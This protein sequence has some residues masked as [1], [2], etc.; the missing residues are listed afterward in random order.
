MN[1]EKPNLIDVNIEMNEK[2]FFRVINLYYNE[3]ELQKIIDSQNN[4][5]LVEEYYLI[6][7]DWIEAFK[8]VFH[9]D[10]NCLISNRNHKPDKTK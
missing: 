6:T 1:N 3:I 2:D 9:Y 8:K 5:V 7:M 10:H 4:N